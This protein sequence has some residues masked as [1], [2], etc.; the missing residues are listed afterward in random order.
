MKLIELKATVLKQM[1][2]DLL[3]DEHPPVSIG[4]PDQ[5]RPVFVNDNT[6][7]RYCIYGLS[8]EMLGGKVTV[9]DM[10]GT[11]DC[12]TEVTNRYFLAAIIENLTLRRFIETEETLQVKTDKSDRKRERRRSV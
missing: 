7:I 8:V 4:D 3:V 9:K 11:M 1:I 12:Y 2:F 5:K 10:T 6:K